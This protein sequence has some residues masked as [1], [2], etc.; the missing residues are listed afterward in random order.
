MYDQFHAWMTEFNI[1]AFAELQMKLAQ[2]SILMCVG[3]QALAEL[4]TI[5]EWTYIEIKDPV[6]W[7][8]ILQIDAGNSRPHP[9]F[10][11]RNFFGFNRLIKMSFQEF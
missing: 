8:V 5:V 3:R 1:R 9:I 6:V 11:F 10:T 4:F 2:L 7:A